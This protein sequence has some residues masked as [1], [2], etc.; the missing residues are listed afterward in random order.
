MPKIKEKFIKPHLTTD[1]Q[2]ERLRSRG[3]SMTDVDTARAWLERIGYYRLSA[4]WYPYRQ[5]RIETDPETG[6][7]LTRREDGFVAQA[8][9]SFV[10]DLYVFD[11]K[12]RLLMLDAIE[13][14]EVA[15]RVAVSDVLGAQNP[16]A[17]LQPQFL[18]GNFTKKLNRNGVPDH[19]EWL[20]ANTDLVRRAKED[21][22]QHFEAKYEDPLPIWVAREVWDFGH[23]SR[24]YSGMTV[25]DKEA[26][27][28]RFGLGPRWNML[29][30]WLRA[31]NHVRNIS[32]HH[33]RLW[34]RGLVD[35]PTVPKTK[36]DIPELD[37]L[38]GDSLAQRHLYA[39]AAVIQF[40]LKVI[41]P[42]SSWGVRFVDHLM[43]LDLPV[44]NVGA[45]GAPDS[46]AE[47][48]LWQPAAK[49]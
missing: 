35:Y 3:M 10:V 41:N 14:I 29:Q 43:S 17:H 19:S 31:I 1:Q 46:W 2:L 44:V 16:W 40:L 25:K 7:L 20:A 5:F 11:K 9:L 30:S 34:N 4:Y 21:F 45:M 37:H 18:H 42:N 27:A 39:T 48:P 32:A 6:R 38:V 24:L 28:A 12:L 36:G 22:V 13:R 49:R 47:L 33:G 15:V 26:V 8:E 23:L